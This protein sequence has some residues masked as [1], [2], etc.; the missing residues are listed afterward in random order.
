M[1]YQVTMDGIDRLSMHLTKIM[2]CNYLLCAL[3]ADLLTDED[4]P[5][6]IRKECGYL[7]LD[8]QREMLHQARA[9]LNSLISG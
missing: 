9:E 6:W 5:G 4:Y 3:D 2:C 8:K 1:S 7:I